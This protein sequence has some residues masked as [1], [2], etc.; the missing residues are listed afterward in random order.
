MQISLQDLHVRYRDYNLSDNPPLIHQKDEVVTPDYPSY[1]KFA[2]LSQQE[3][4][5][6]LL[7]DLSSVYHLHSW[8]KFLV[9]RCAELKGHRL[10]WKKGA[11]PYQK[12]IA[13]AAIR[14]RKSR[15]DVDA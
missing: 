11:D 12:R 10:V 4:D 2:K 1:K 7:D 3:K 9:S 13:K 8:Q 14:A 6:G 15:I 5:W